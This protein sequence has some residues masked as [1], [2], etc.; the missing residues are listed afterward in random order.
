MPSIMKKPKKDIKMKTLITAIV[1]ALTA[2]LASAEDVSQQFIETEFSDNSTEAQRDF[3]W[4][5]IDGKWTSL[6]G[7]VYD[8][9]APGWLLKEYQ[10]TMHLDNGVAVYCYIPESQFKRV[11]NVRFNDEFTCYGKLRGYVNLFGSSGISID[12]V[13]DKPASYKKKE[14][15]VSKEISAAIKL[16]KANGYTVTK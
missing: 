15:V 10:V 11:K 5:E 7:T 12:S 16:L 14:V 9:D 8:V 1:I 3:A 13:M 6:T 2:T 4:K